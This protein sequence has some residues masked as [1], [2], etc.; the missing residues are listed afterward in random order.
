MASDLLEIEWFS[1]LCF[2]DC[3][4]TTEIIGNGCIGEHCYVLLSEELN[5]LVDDMGIGRDIC[6]VRG[7]S[8]VPVE[9]DCTD[10]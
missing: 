8:V 5:G 4:P 9:D 6:E 7:E 1:L 10:S 3:E 2:D